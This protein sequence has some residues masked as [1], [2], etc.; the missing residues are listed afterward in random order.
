MNEARP[1]DNIYR[2]GD[3]MEIK[4]ECQHENGSYKG[5][6]QLWCSDCGIE[7]DMITRKPVVK[8]G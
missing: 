4:T 2:E 6:R 8:E 1:T 5:T 7:L 3:K